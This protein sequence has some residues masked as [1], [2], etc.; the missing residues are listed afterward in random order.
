MKDRGVDLAFRRAVLHSSAR[1]VDHCGHL[2]TSGLCGKDGYLWQSAG[3]EEE[4]LTIFLEGPSFVEELELEADTAAGLPEKVR[5][6]V[7]AGKDT[8]WVEKPVRGS[9]SAKQPVW[10]GRLSEPVRCERVKVVLTGAGGDCFSIGRLSLYGQAE[11]PCPKPARAWPEPSSERADL[12]GGNWKLLRAPEVSE[13][14]ETLSKSGYDDGAWIDAVVPGTALCSYL[15]GGMIPDPDP[16]DHHLQLSDRYFLCDYWYRAAFTLPKTVSGKR[17]LLHLD[18][19]NWKGEIYFNGKKAGAMAGAF[20]RGVFDL[21]DLAL[22]GEENALAVLV[23][24]NATPG[25]VKCHR[26]DASGPNGG[27]LGADNPTIHASAGWDWINT[28]KGRNVGLYG[29]V[30]IS[31]GT[32]LWVDDPA[33]DV[34]LKD[35]VAELTL[36]ARVKNYGV[37]V[38]QVFLQASFERDIPT[39]KSEML[40]LEPG[41]ETEV[42]LGTVSV[43]G[44]RL[45]WPNTYGEPYLYRGQI[46]ALTDDGRVEAQKELEI[47]LREIRYETE[48]HVRLFCNGVR[49]VCRGGNWGMPDAN[50]RADAFDYETK[51]RFHAHANFTMIRNWVGMTNDEEFYRACDRYGILIW[52]DFWLANP[53]DGP[54]PDDEEMFLENAL[55]KIRH[56]RIHP[57]L[58]LY[59]GRNEGMPPETLDRGLRALVERE[60][61]TRL[62]IP[63][64]ASCGVSGLGPYCIQL[65]SWYFENTKETL[66][67]ERGLL[68]IPELDTMKRMLTPAHAWPPDE[69]WAHHDFCMNR[70]H[71]KAEQTLERMKEGYDPDFNSLE[72]FVRVAQIVDFEAHRAMFE[73][74]HAVRGEGLL[75]WM[76]SPC[77]LS[78]TWQTYDW[79]YDINGGYEGCRAGNIPVHALWNSSQD[80]VYLLNETGK[81]L[82]GLRVVLE[83][84]SLKG[85]R[86]LTR[87]RV[88][89]AK[90]DSCELMEKLPGAKGPVVT[91]FLAG[92]D[93][94]E[95]AAP[96]PPELKRL[97][98]IRL[99]VY[100]RE[101][102]RLARE[103]YW[104][105]PTRAFDSR[106]FASLPQAQAQVY[107]EK[108]GENEKDRV[109]SMRV[110]N[111]RIPFL[112]AHLTL[113]DREGERILPAF[114]SENYLVMMPG[115]ETVVKACVPKSVS[116]VPESV[117]LDGFNLSP[118]VIKVP[119]PA[120][121]K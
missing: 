70:S 3:R 15:E 39:L 121:E 56:Y 65:P 68:N 96:M 5:V 113:L 77:Q 8:D 42:N 11:H 40:R 74:E 59:C 100:D 103:D 67:S 109:Y 108:S 79:C 45:W 99:S 119:A 48:P 35:G 112:M 46:R 75:M 16:A 110:R 116:S 31:F 32:D 47:G 71:Q 19:L 4:S 78:M 57:S 80:A 52:D 58:A 29:N 9:R 54:E 114:W 115:E 86:I 23:R 90:A 33:S 1:D 60:D 21:T 84:Y 72:E 102:T 101:G 64:S 36:K 93:G 66:H 26:L 10:S 41:Q 87:T 50:L 27:V 14:G 69:V 17:I 44:P 94:A 97:H 61:G 13:G 49:I 95:S 73:A 106:D 92:A 34:R 28:V 91:E 81:N 43:S 76:S 117:R 98:F 118:V 25:P 85:I 38:R 2:V 51:V 89:D 22:P 18:A 6:F 7:G 88:M 20:K 24:T 120:G 111:G 107:W 63:H 53:V 37:S 30:W 62:Y 12:K 104:R 55:D 82:S 105:N 83:A